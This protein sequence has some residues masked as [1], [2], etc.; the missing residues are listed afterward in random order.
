[1]R[2]IYRSSNGGALGTGPSGRLARNGGS[3]VLFCHGVQGE[4]V[5]CCS[6]AGMIQELCRWLDACA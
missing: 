6:K 1:M 3:V 5:A 4:M 2:F